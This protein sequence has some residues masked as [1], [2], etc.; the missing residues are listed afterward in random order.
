MSDSIIYAD[1]TR[2]VTLT[3]HSVVFEHN[4]GVRLEFSRAAMNEIVRGYEREKEQQEEAERE[5]KIAEWE[6]EHGRP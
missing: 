2:K 6:L 5:R 4:I 3:P 1:G